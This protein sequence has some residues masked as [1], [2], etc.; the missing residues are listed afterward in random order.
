MQTV[1]IS[2]RKR[3]MF[4]KLNNQRERARVKGVCVCVCV[5]GGGYRLLG[6]AHCF[7]KVL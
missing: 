7:S 6:F 4:K 3:S 1:A 5:G 2:R